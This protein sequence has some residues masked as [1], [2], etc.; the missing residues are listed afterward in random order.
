MKSSL[1][2]RIT[3]FLGLCCQA[4]ALSPLLFG[5]CM[6]EIQSDLHQSNHVLRD[7]YQSRFPD[8]RPL[9]PENMGILRQGE[10]SRGAV[11]LL[12]G[13]V[14]TPAT[15]NPLID[16]LHA[17]GLTVL[18]PLV[19]GFGGD[20]QVVNTFSLKDWQDAVDQSYMSLSKCFEDIGVLGFSMGAALG[21]DFALER[22]SR[23]NGAILSSITL[24]SPFMDLN[25]LGLKLLNWW[26]RNGEV[27]PLQTLRGLAR[28][29]GS[30]T[31]DLDVMIAK[32]S[33]FNQSLPVQGVRNLLKLRDKLEKAQAEVP[34]T[35]PAYLVYSQKDGVADPLKG[36]EV[37]LKHFA[38]ATVHQAFA[39]QN[40]PHMLDI[41]QYGS[42]F[43]L[44]LTERVL[45]FI[46]DSRESYLQKSPALLQ[47]RG[48]IPGQALRDSSGPFL[49]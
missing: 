34:P 33:S 4:E 49:R 35:L 40:V 29:A 44:A 43:G 8:S 2:I 17:R 16:S 23:L 45:H 6:Q 1:G 28:A 30:S 42:E 13:F 31:A 20:T 3:L 5:D 36:R 37:V 39:S 18:A 21:L 12:H 14:S 10:E 24:L 46:E 19:P 7:S 48:K 38:V 9:Q 41:H 27:V 22:Y 47:A 32:P 15:L 25:G 26:Y 11:L